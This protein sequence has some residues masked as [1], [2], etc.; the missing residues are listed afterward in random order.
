MRDACPDADDELCRRCFELT[1]GNPLQLRELLAAIEQQAQPADAAALAAAA[2]VAARSLARSV[3]RRLAAL[4]PDA[5]ALARGVAVFEDDAPLHLAAELTGLAAAAALA[6]ADELARADVLR[7]GDP[8][9]FTHPLVRAAVYGDLPFGERARTHRRAARLLVESGAVERARERAPARV[10]RPRATPSWWSYL[11]ATAQRALARGA[12]ASAVRYLERALREPP[13]DAARPAVLAELGRAEAAAGL[14]DAIAHLEAAIGLAGEPRQRAALLLAFGRVL[15]HGG[16]LSDAC[17]AFQRGRDELGERRSELAVDLEAGYLAAAMQA[18]DRAAEAHRQADAILAAGGRRNRAE[19]EL[20]S[21][22]MVMRLW[23]GAPRDEILAIARR[24]FRDAERAHEDRDDSRAI[25]HV[26]GCLSLCDDYAAAETALGADVRRRAAA[27]LGVDVRG[28]LAAARAAAAVDRA[29]RRRRA[30]RPRRV[31]RL[32]RRAAHVPAPRRLL[33][34]QRACS[35]RTSPTRPS[36]R[37]RSAS[38]SRPPS[39]SSPHGGTP[40]SGASPSG[41][42]RTTPALEAFLA[43]GPAPGRAAGDQSRPCCRGARRR[44]WPRSG[45]AATS[46]RAR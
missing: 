19:R 13:A 5:Q 27:G 35:S 12:P 42:A 33:P 25:V 43:S 16:R 3:L 7:P 4:S 46:R 26:T 40:R 37:W 2:E 38:A 45:S 14:P 22:A 8:L 44:G 1:A 23:G 30:R 21:K 39:A 9:G 17:A 11:R 32:A 20:A 31:R 34:G 6:A 36:G 10:R 18:P 24:L 41:A 28:G 29:R 15:Q